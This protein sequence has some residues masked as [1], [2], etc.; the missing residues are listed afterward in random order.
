[1]VQQAFDKAGGEGMIPPQF[2]PDIGDVTIDFTTVL[3]E[4][5]VSE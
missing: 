2:D 5:K 4:R 1:M 3:E